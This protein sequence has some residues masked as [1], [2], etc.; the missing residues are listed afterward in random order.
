MLSM[1]SEKVNCE[2]GW[3]GLE[4]AAVAAVGAALELDGR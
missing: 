4:F 1:S 2:G 3:R